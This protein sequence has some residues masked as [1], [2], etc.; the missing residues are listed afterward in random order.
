MPYGLIENGI[1]IQKQLD[2]QEGFIEIPDNVVCGMY[3]DGNDFIMPDPDEE[4]SIP[5]YPT[6]QIITDRIT[7]EPYEV[8]IENGKLGSNKLEMQNGS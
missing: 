2:P 3:F 7:G 4:P 6:E 8:F 1:L 5:S